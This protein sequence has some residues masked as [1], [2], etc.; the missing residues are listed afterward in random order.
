MLREFASLLL[1][2]HGSDRR[3]VERS[4]TVLLEHLSFLYRY[5]PTA[6]L[7]DPSTQRINLQ[8]EP[9]VGRDEMETLMGSGSAADWVRLSELVLGPAPAG[10]TFTPKHKS[11]AYESILPAQ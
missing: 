6:L 4:R 10:F 3:G 2:V 5:T 1:E 8:P 7:S 11:N 9:F